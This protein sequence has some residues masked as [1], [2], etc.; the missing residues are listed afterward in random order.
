V[1]VSSGGTGLDLVIVPEPETVVLASIG[2]FMAGWS[3]WKRRRIAAICHPDS[4][5]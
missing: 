3:L 4:R 1:K 2:A 5:A